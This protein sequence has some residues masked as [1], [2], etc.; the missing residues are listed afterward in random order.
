MYSTYIYLRI[1]N[2][3]GPLVYPM[4]SIVIALVCPSVSLSLNILETAHWFLLTLDP[5][6]SR[7]VLSNRPCPSM[8]RWSVSEYLR[9]RSLVYPMEFTFLKGIVVTLLVG[10][11]VRRKR[12]WDFCFFGIIKSVVLDDFFIFWEKIF[13]G[14]LC[15]FLTI[16]L[17]Y[18]GLLD[19]SKEASVSPTD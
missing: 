2:Y 6:F 17:I 10:L 19:F 4:G 11:S 15:P 12:F 5:G 9:D 16:F 7:G 18:K 14:L 13:S 1:E 3:F 8:V